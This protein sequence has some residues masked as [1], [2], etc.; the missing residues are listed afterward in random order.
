MTRLRV[1]L[2]EQGLGVQAQLVG[3][4]G[5]YLVQTLQP[6]AAVQ[7][8][9]RWRWWLGCSVERG[10]AGVLAVFQLRLQHLRVVLAEIDQRG[11]ALATHHFAQA[12]A[13]RLQHHV[14]GAV[15]LLREDDP[16]EAVAVPALFA[17][18]HQQHHAMG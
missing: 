18:L 9:H 15:A 1:V 2:R 16:G 6:R 17:N 5:R 7:H 12:A 3:R 10:N 14:G 11:V 4:D 8:G 13:G